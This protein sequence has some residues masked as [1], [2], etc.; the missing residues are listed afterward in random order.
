MKQGLSREAIAMRAARELPDGA[1]VNLGGGIPTLVANFLPKGRTVIFHTENGALGFGPAPGREP[2][3][4]A[5]LMG[6]SGSPFMPLPGMCLFDHATSFAMIRGGHIDVTVLGALQV[7]EKG[8]LANWTFPERGLGNIGGGMD[9]AFGCGQVIVTMQHV[10]PR[11]EIKIL[12]ECT[13]P[14]TAPRCVSLMVTDIAVIE[15]LDTGL[16]LREV[17]PG[18]TVDEVQTL[19][20]PKLTVA[21]DLKEIQL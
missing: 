18:W 11:G 1:V 3:A 8:D 13:Y 17:A 10:T 19:T 12:T 4:Q 15:V 14:L 9:L 7:S 6:A 20:G 21:E 16:V 5:H 2:D